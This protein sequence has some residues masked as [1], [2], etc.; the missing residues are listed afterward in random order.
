MQDLGTKEN[1]MIDRP[2]KNR[3]SYPSIRLPLSMIGKRRVGDQVTVILKGEIVSMEDTRYTK[4]F[5][6]DAK[7]GEIS[8]A[9]SIDLQ[10][11]IGEALNSKGK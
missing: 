1:T 11:K 4:S 3:V 7:K 5:T 8:S 9:K 2:I 10:D 6:V